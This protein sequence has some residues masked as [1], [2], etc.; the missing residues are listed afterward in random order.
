MELVAVAVAEAPKAEVA[1]AEVAR[2]E[3]LQEEAAVKVMAVDGQV[4]LAIRP[5]EGG[6]MH[7]PAAVKSKLGGSVS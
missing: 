4:E 7:Q 1:R 2:A 5:E 3:G 6:V